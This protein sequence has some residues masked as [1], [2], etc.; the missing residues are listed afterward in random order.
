MDASQWMA[1][2]R[3]VHELIRKGGGTEEE[4]ELH[5][6][7]CEELARSMMA[8][9]GQQATSGLEARKQFRVAQVYPIEVD[10]LYRAVTRDVSCSAFSAVLP[11]AFKVGQLATFSLQLARGAEPITGQARA[12]EVV[13]QKGSAKVT[14][15]I[16]VLGTMASELLE[17]ALFDA[18][19]ARIK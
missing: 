19:L 4:S 14:F 5:R 6:G 1:R 10:N 9:Q 3:S 8:S 11:D 2:F 12:T 15:G 17:L 16:E 18:V 7:M 13:K